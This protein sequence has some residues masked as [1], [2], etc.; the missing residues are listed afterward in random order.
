MNLPLASRE[1]GE[2]V[3]VLVFMVLSFDL[4]GCF[5]RVWFGDI[6]V[7]QPHY[8]F[9]KVVYSFGNQNKLLNC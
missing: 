9:T 4:F 8:T 1:E 6:Q 5:T 2:S 7:I 3:T